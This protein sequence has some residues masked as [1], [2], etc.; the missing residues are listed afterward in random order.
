MARSGNLSIEEIEE[1]TGIK[2]PKDL[3]E[4]MAPRRQMEA[5][6][7]KPGK[8]HCFD[9][10]FILVCGD[11]EIETILYKRLKKI[12]YDFKEPICLEVEED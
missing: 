12:P 8:W 3:K 6:N 11:N 10:P 9:S 7:I 5:S 4:Y 1:K 2:F